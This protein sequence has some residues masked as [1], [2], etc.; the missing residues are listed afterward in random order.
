MPILLAIESSTAIASVALHVAAADAAL[1]AR[2]F[3]RSAS[4]VQSHSHSILP[5]VQEVLAEAGLTL[6]DCDAI[7]FGAG[8]GSFTGVRTACGIAQGLGYGSS[9]PVIAVDTLAAAAQACRDATGAS[10]VLVV[11]DA[12]MGEVYWG[13]YRWH[14][15]E[16]GA[17]WVSVTAARLDAPARV[18][19][20]VAGLPTAC[21]NGLAAHA[22]HFLGCDTD[23][24]ARADI[25]PH[26]IQVAFLAQRL[27]AQGA[28]VAARDAQPIYL[29]NDVAQ[30]TA[31]R[32]SR[33]LE[34]SA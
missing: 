14:D 25:M 27:F 24:G 10:N 5:M 23:A 4:G 34:A 9:R 30:T 1:P 28:A 18:A 19:P 33:R 15:G 21:G 29:R 7:A 13:Q 6:H 31:E 32:E 16:D 22:T 11:L 17:G 8:P 20:A 2:V 26:A 3:S 12:R